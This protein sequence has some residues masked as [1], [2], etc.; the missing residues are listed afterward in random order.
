MRPNYCRSSSVP[1]GGTHGYRKHSRAKGNSRAGPIIRGR[2]RSGTEEPT[3]P[4]VVR[5]RASA[6][7]TSLPARKYRDCRARA[8]NSC[9]RRN[10]Y[11]RQVAAFSFARRGACTGIARERGAPRQKKGRIFENT[12]N[13]VHQ[14]RPIRRCQTIRDRA[15]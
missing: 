11:T 3:T 1:R 13:T 8:L 9:A 10:G 15:H 4:A 7:G 2:A 5:R 12:S 14:V 6:N